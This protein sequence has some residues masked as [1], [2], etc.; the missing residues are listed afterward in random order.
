MGARSQV[1]CRSLLGREDCSAKFS[2]WGSLTRHREK[3]HPDLGRWTTEESEDKKREW[4]RLQDAGFGR[5]WRSRHHEDKFDLSRYREVYREPSAEMTKMD[6]NPED[7]NP[8]RCLGLEGYYRREWQ[9]T[10]PAGRTPLACHGWREAPVNEA[11][12]LK[13]AKELPLPRGPGPKGEYC[14]PETIADGRLVVVESRPVPSFRDEM[15]QAAERRS[16]LVML[17]LQSLE[18][19]VE[20]DPLKGLGDIEVT[21]RQDPPEEARPA[22]RGDGAPLKRAREEDHPEAKRLCTAEVPD[23]LLQTRARDCLQGRG[24]RAAGKAGAHLTMLVKAVVLTEA[25]NQK[26]TRPMTAR[27]MRSTL[28]DLSTKRR[29]L[30]DVMIYLTREADEALWAVQGRRQAQF[31]VEEVCGVEVGEVARPNLLCPGLLAQM[32]EDRVRLEVETA[33]LAVEARHTKQRVEDLEKEGQVTKARA[34]ETGEA[35]RKSEDQCT[36]LRAQLAAAEAEA[37]RLRE[38]KEAQKKQHVEELA[39]LRDNREATPVVAAVRLFTEDQVREM[40]GWAKCLQE[41][42]R[43]SPPFLNP[44]DA[45]VSTEKEERP[46]PA[47]VPA[48]QEPKPAEGEMLPAAGAA[49]DAEEMETE[50]SPT[51]EESEDVEPCSEVADAPLT[52]EEELL[53]GPNEEAAEF[54]YLEVD[55]EDEPTLLLHPELEDLDGEGS[56]DPVAAPTE[57]PETPQAPTPRTPEEK[58]ARKKAKKLMKKEK[59]KATEK[60][61]RKIEKAEKR[62]RR[63]ED[64]STASSTSEDS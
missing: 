4:H 62:A 26:N 5:T 37:R 17:E 9:S 44:V 38:E 3:Q 57:D 10:L 33:S 49:T 27:E 12:T 11:V 22:E 13:M 39:G 25:Q 48:A 14:E 6:V 31:P 1:R 45:E 8:Y 60:Q 64:A 35:M 61:R 54:D 40:E 46:T 32:K 51:P 53:A 15:V 19:P 43:T 7:L 28:E 56:E 30:R 41:A 58:I 47:E 59:K 34:L 16:P 23:H 2:N 21:P 24:V 42:L 18:N 20:E 63:K 55:L 52:Q 36:E 29:A 50:D